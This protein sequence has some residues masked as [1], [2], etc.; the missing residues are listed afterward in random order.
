MQS[1]KKTPI[2]WYVIEKVKKLRIE[3]NLSQSELSYKLHLSHGF[4]GKVESK[5]LVT[6]YN[7]NH[8][9]KLSIALG[10][11]PQFFLPQQP[12]NE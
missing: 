6:K 10:C 7:L 8:L 12:I 1:N 4:V 3:K 2:E 9:N 5:N 11:S